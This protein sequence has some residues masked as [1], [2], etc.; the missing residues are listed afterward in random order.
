MS[1]PSDEEFRAAVGDAINQGVDGDVTAGAI[2]V[3]EMYTSYLQA[4]FTMGQAIYLAG[5][6]VT[7]NPGM[8][9]GR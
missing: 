3:H 5:C 8:I 6:A 2:A 4:G 9:T 1:G 7:G